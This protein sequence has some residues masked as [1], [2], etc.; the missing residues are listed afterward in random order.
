MY[1][2][3]IA[4]LVM[5]MQDNDLPMKNWVKNAI[6]FVLVW[7]TFP[8]DWSCI[9]VLAILEMY[10]RRG[11]LSAQMKIML[12]F[13]AI[14]AA[15]SLC[16]GTDWC[17]T[18]LPCVKTIQWRKGESKMDEMVFLSILSN[19][20]DFYWSTSYL[21]LRGYP[22]IVLAVFLPPNTPK[23]TPDTRRKPCTVPHPPDQSPGNNNI[24]HP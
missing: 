24:R 1:P 14:Y 7:S 21:Y 16:F 20:F 5:W 12:L 11:N 8:A 23:T 13:V 4:V 17:F 3:F 9:A 22:F 18:G 19:P 2:L 10:K 15:V 6:I